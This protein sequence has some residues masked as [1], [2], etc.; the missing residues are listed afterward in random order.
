MSD[1]AELLPRQRGLRSQ[2]PRRRW[3]PCNSALRYFTP[4][5]RPQHGTARRRRS[6]HRFAS[7]W[8]LRAQ[9]PPWLPRWHRWISHMHACAIAP[10]ESPVRACMNHRID[11]IHL[12]FCTCTCTSVRPVECACERAPSMHAG[13]PAPCVLSPRGRRWA[14]RE[15][16]VGEEG[17]FSA[18]CI[19]ICIC[20]HGSRKAARPSV[21]T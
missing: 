9:N 20:M 2:L 4:S 19:G 3:A 7:C 5:R 14:A 17:A 1:N 21:R 8:L 11:S 12:T 18:A 6:G 15:A 13:R 10:I 16:I